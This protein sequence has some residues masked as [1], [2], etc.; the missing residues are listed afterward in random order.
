MRSSDRLRK[1]VLLPGPET[2][3]KRSAKLMR[4]L[5]GAAL[6]LAGTVMLVLPAPGAACLIAGASLLGIPLPKRVS[7]WIHARPKL[8]AIVRYVEAPR[9]QNRA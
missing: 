7:A 1:V 8:A 3:Q 2:P 6:I 5:L 9:S 4:T